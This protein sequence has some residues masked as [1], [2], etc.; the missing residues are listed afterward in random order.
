M[1]LRR[2]KELSMEARAVIAGEGRSRPAPRIAVG[3]IFPASPACASARSDLGA[4]IVALAAVLLVM[5][6]SSESHAFRSAADVPDFATSNAVAFANPSV[7]VELFEQIPSDLAPAAVDLAIRQA[8]ETWTAAGCTGLQLSYAGRTSIAAA[9]GDGRNTIQWVS[10]W[11]ER[12]F[13]RQAPGLT[14]VQYLKNANGN[15]IIA[16]ADIYLNLDFD[17]STDAPTAQRKSVL[18]VLTHELGHLIGLMHVCEPNGSDGAPVCADSAQFNGEVMYPIYSASQTVL[19]DDDLAGVCFLYPEQV[20]TPVVPAGPSEGC[21]EPSCV[22]A[23]AQQIRTAGSVSFAT[24]RCARAVKRRSVT[25]VRPPLSVHMVR[26]TR[27]FAPSRA[28]ALRCVRTLRFATRMPGRVPIRSLPWARAARMPMIAAEATASPKPGMRRN[29]RALVPSVTVLVPQA[30]PVSGSKTRPSARR[31]LPASLVAAASG[32]PPVLEAARFFL[33]FAP[34]RSSHGVF[35]AIPHG[36]DYETQQ[37]NPSFRSRSARLCDLR[38][39][40]VKKRLVRSF[41][42]KADRERERRG[43]TAA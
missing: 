10:G 32:L 35:A 27:A 22:A 38:L 21:N 26:A 8:A 33:R 4:R 11:K 14:D 25:P 16:E 41:A 34:H 28:R 13:P 30:G 39:Q 12:G 9:A 23:R 6:A 5:F 37:D 19:T 31:A 15:W 42:G 24:A 29:A 2:S 40:R 1:R 3:W 7:N 20:A 36:Q 18:A 43:R 17:W